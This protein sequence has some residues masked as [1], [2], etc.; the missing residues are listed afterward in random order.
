MKRTFQNLKAGTFFNPRT[1][2][3]P[4]LIFLR[5][6]PFLQR[7]WL[8]YFNLDPQD[9]D[10]DFD[11]SDTD[12][13]IDSASKRKTKFNGWQYFMYDKLVISMPWVWL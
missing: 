8:N 12:C 13:D 9:A 10:A 6:T 1:K 7:Y 3:Q 4:V 2:N 11:A 5:V